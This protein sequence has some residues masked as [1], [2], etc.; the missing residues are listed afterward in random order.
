MLFR[1]SKVLK[2]LREYHRVFL[3]D[4]PTNVIGS[5]ELEALREIEL[6]QLAMA[7]DALKGFEYFE[8]QVDGMD[9]NVR[10]NLPD[11]S[12]YKPSQKL[13]KPVTGV[14]KAVRIVRNL[15][16]LKANDFPAEVQAEVLFIK[17]GS[18]CWKRCL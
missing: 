12:R 9:V 3:T 5:E 7:Y 8:E 10:F 15:A 18:T 1:K 11:Y 2:V 4:I 16:F 14:A 17:G 13:A 6:E